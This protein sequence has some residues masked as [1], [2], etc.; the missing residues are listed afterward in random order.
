MSE[1]KLGIENIKSVM[2]FMADGRNMTADALQ[3]GKIT[4]IEGVGFLPLIM[5]T[6][7]IVASAKETLAEIK[8]ATHTERGTL[9]TYAIVELNI[10]SEEVE[11]FIAKCCDWI[12]LTI[13]LFDS[14]TKLAA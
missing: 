3:D 9:E 8:D 14:G 7:E 6:P 1:N 2:K 10:P 5:R 12:I 13:Q 4:W 11:A